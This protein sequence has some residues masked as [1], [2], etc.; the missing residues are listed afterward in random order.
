MILKV[1]NWD[2]FQHYKDRRPPWIKLHFA[3]L[4]SK[5]WVML[6]DSERVL[7]IACMLVASQSDLDPGC[8]EADPDYIKRVAYLNTDPDFK[9]LIDQ[10]F[11]R[12]VK[13]DD[14]ERKH[15]LSDA[16]TEAEAEADSANADGEPSLERQVWSK[17]LEALARISGKSETQCRT[18]LGKW[19]KDHDDSAVLSAVMEAERQAVSDPAAWITATLKA[20]CPAGRSKVVDLYR[21]ILVPD[22][23]DVIDLDA[24]RKRQIGELSNGQLKSMDQWRAFFDVVADSEVL[25]GRKPW[26]NGEVKAVDFDFLLKHGVKIMEGKY[27]D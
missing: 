10:G 12:V 8:F 21:E 15:L 4:S 7:A 24:D 3:I 6:S 18:L 11:L 23:P 22:L 9:P 25:T 26:R 13:A 19:R 2:K 5:D 27:D 14:S 16:R 1:R 20:R 17:G